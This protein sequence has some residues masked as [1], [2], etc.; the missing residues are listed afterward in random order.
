MYRYGNLVANEHIIAL[1]CPRVDILER[2]ESLGLHNIPRRSDLC[3]ADP[4][5]I[6]SLVADCGYKKRTIPFSGTTPGEAF[7]EFEFSF[8][9][10]TTASLY[11]TFQ[12]QLGGVPVIM[13]V[14]Y[15]R[16]TIL[17]IGT[18]YHLVSGRDYQWYKLPESIEQYWVVSCTVERD[19]GR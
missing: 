4:K 6:R 2:V 12:L 10:E 19:S 18:K 11:A 17:G 13:G 7:Q 9:K 15:D 8:E 3:G 16:T 14:E 5:T 1:G